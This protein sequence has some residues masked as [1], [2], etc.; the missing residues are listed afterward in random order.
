MEKNSFETQRAFCMQQYKLCGL[1]PVTI[2]L[3]ISLPYNYISQYGIY[4]H[5][6][7]V[8]KNKQVQ[9]QAVSSPA[10]CTSSGREVSDNPKASLVLQDKQ[11]D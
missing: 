9:E 4:M 3:Q 2:G 7:C 11:L 5:H 6:M 8:Q 10:G 1:H